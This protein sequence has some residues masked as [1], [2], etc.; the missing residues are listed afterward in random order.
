MPEERANAFGQPSQDRYLAHGAKPYLT[1]NVSWE[2]GP[3]FRGKGPKGY[4]RTD[5]RIQEDICERLTEDERVDAT[6]IEVSIN[7]AEVRLS[8]MVRTRGERRRAEELVDAISGVQHVQND[9]RVKETD[10]RYNE[11][12]ADERSRGTI[13]SRNIEVM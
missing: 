13:G 10:G 9:I 11:Q 2:A 7:N 8:G 4:T 6:N 1:G 5:D 3:G 12:E